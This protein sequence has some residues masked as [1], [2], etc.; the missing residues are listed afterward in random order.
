MKRFAPVI[1]SMTLLAAFPSALGAQASL[2]L[3][4]PAPPLQISDWVKGS[5][6]TLEAGRGSKIHVVEFWATWCPPCRMSIPH[7]TELQKK[8][9]DK[10]VTIIGV[11][12]E[13]PGTVKPFV[14]KQGEAMAY[15]V[16]VDR[17]RATYDAY[18][19]AFGV[20]GIPHAFVIDKEGRIVWH[21]H[22]MGN[23]DK[24]IENVLAGTHDVEKTKREQ[25][26]EEK[27]PR[28]FELAVKGDPGARAVGESILQDAGSH[29]MLLNRMAWAI[30]TAP[31]IKNRDLDLAERVARAG[32]EA[33]EAKDASVLDTYARVLHAAGKKEQAIE[34]QKKAISV[35]TD[36]KERA[37]YEQTLRQYEGKAGSR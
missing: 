4:A 29:V 34:M 31:Q 1:A 8:Y 26:A 3:G 15:T 37:G 21:G 20:A 28:Y 23:L 6:I 11:S 2:E 25:A 9:A 24:T 36:D 30:V 18:M 33:S 7:L 27:L 19:K 12:T 10:G 5:S 16:A 32:V 22:P 13:D 17:D 14:S 35:A